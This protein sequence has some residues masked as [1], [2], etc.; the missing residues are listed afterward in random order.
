MKRLVYCIAF[1]GALLT[2]AA[3]HNS[4]WFTAQ[5][6]VLQYHGHDI[7]FP[8]PTK[9]GCSYLMSEILSSS[10]SFSPNDLK[11]VARIVRNS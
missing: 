3:A 8:T 2:G 11:C 10:Q 5:G 6:W 9:R 7:S 1:S 4:T